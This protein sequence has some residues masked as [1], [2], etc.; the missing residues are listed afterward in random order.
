MSS[1]PPDP[2]DLTAP[3][4]V[5]LCGLGYGFY[6]AQQL[7]QSP[8]ARFV[9]FV[10][11]S[12]LRADRLA[13]ATAVLGCPGRASLDEL[14]ADP[15]V[16]A[17]ALFTGPDRRADLVRRIVRAGKHVMTTK[18]FELDAAAGLAAL[19]EA[20]ALGR[21]V[22]LNSPAPV[23]GEDLQQVLAWREEFGLGRL[24]SMTAFEPSLTHAAPP[25]IWDPAGQDLVNRVF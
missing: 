14:I 21:T 18:P 10:A 3:I 9:R 12:D 20:R 1:T 5:G 22:F 6:H 11:A 13:T 19:E 7:L 25:V 16:E 2:S 24:I 8:Y 23:L 15:E 4:R 17:I